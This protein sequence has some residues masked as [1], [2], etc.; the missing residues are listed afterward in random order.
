MRIFT[1]PKSTLCDYRFALSIQSIISDRKSTQRRQFL[2]SLIKG[3]LCLSPC[4]KSPRLK[5]KTVSHIFFSVYQHHRKNFVPF[6]CRLMAHIIALLP[7]YA[8]PSSKNVRAIT[9]HVGNDTGST[10]RH[11][12]P[13]SACMPA[14]T[15][16][17]ARMK[18]PSH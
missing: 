9:R 17:S 16:S 7:A 12:S 4:A 10:K 14:N 3:F 18:N 11:Y 2:A 8:H 6:W 5:A 15:I 1:R 13:T